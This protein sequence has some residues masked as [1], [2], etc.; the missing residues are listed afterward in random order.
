VEAS[1]TIT[2]FIN[3]VKRKAYVDFDIDEHDTVMHIVEAGQF[4]NANGF[5]PELAPE[6]VDSD[7]TIEDR[8]S[9]VSNRVSFYIRATV[10]SLP[11]LTIV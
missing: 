2:Q 7:M 11:H 10:G 4:N 8:Y 6:L 9:N 1:S 3:D 5:E